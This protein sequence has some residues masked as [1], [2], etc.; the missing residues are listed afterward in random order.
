MIAAGC[1]HGCAVGGGGRDPAE[2]VADLLQEQRAVAGQAL[3]AGAHHDAAVQRHHPPAQGPSKQPCLADTGV[4]PR[5][6]MVLRSIKA[7]P[8]G[9]GL[10]GSVHRQE[11]SAGH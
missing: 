6:P 7:L 11:L 2:Q 10:H 8:G 5:E 9:T 4:L 3:E 1:P